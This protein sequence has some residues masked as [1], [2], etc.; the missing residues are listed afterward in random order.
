MSK[1]L[2]FSMKEIPSWS[3][4]A[5][6]EGIVRPRYIKFFTHEIEEE[7][8]LQPLEN[9]VNAWVVEG[10]AQEEGREIHA[11]DPIP[12]YEDDVLVQLTLVITYL[13]YKTQRD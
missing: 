8:G 3:R 6:P 12:E 13:K 9:M 5:I 10:Y 11:I 2:P 1:K 7:H 4:R